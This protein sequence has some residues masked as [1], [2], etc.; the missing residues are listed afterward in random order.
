MRLIT[1]IVKNIFGSLLLIS[2]N[3]TLPFEI[4]HNAL[5]HG[6]PVLFSSLSLHPCV[7]LC[8]VPVIW[9]IH[10]CEMHVYGI[11]P[12]TMLSEGRGRYPVVFSLTLSTL[13]FQTESLNQTKFMVS[14]RMIGQCFLS[15]LLSTAGVTSTCGCCWLFYVLNSCPCEFRTN[16]SI[17]ETSTYFLE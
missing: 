7:C 12:V 3:R 6:T 10:V 13:R 17:S 8:T 2:K 9:M 1:A 15:I 16:F 11:C 14:A 4:N 5:H